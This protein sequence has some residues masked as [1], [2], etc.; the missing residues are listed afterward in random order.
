MLYLFFTVTLF[1]PLKQ[2]K[3]IMS[4]S[5]EFL[6][7]RQSLSLDSKINMS[8][9]RI[10]AF[11]EKLQGKV[12]IAFSGGKDS[13][14][15]LHLVRSV[16][17]D[18][19]A[20]FSDTGLE[21]PEIRKFVKTF[22]NVTVIRPEMSFKKVIETYGYP[23]ISKKVARQIRDLKN[24]TENNKATRK[25]Y[26]TGEKRDGTFSK[27]FKLPQKWK[28]LIDA[29]FKISEQCCNIMKKKPF[30]KYKKETGRHPYIGVMASDSEQRR[31]SYMK[32]GCNSFSNK[33]QS[34]PLAFW[35][36]KDIDE[37]L[38]KFNLPYCNIYDKGVDHTGCIFCMFGVHLDKEPNRFQMLARTHPKLHKY[39]IEKLEIGKVLDYINVPY[40]FK[41][42]LEDYFEKN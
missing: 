24:P 41:P 32:T 40:K 25:L 13:T 5:Y 26:L 7:Q 4:I 35:L 2:Y 11:Y 27:N 1:I 29:P 22:D 3:K 15:L 8:K 10:R 37:Y 42:F 6:K 18:I 36:R 16:Y 34:K 21:Y 31:A 12:Y 19:P 30:Q 14:V 39:C 38:E 17:P 33:I 23:V 20:V 9:R 28:F